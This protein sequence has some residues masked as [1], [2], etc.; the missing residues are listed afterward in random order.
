[1][2]Q[3]N[4][5]STGAVLGWR[6]W[7]MNS[8]GTFGQLF[9][10]GI[11]PYNGSNACRTAAPTY[12]SV[13]STSTYDDI[14]RQGGCLHTDMQFGNGTS[15]DLSRLSAIFVNTDN[16][17]SGFGSCIDC[18]PTWNSPPYMGI[19]RAGCNAATCAYNVICR[20]QTAAS[21]ADCTGSYCAGT[22]GNGVCPT[23]AN[24]GTLTWNTR[25]FVK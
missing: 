21:T 13:G 15:W 8:A 5:R 10:G 20:D 23:S 19:D 4:D 18:G 1:M 6:I 12:S 22:Y 24:T 14:I 3:S 25:I 2:I 9:S 16:L 11:A 17:M 7:P